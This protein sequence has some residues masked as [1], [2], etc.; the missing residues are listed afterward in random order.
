MATH[1]QALKRYRQNE[2][3]R[4][5]NS[6]LKSVMKTQVKKFSDILSSKSSKKVQEEFKNTESLIRKMSSKGIIPKKRASRKISRLSR[7]IK[8]K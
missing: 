3:K 2:K 5:R 4:M 6:Q 8:T 1:K 7:K